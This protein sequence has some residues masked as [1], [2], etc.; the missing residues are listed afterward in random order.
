V[1]SLIRSPP[2]PPYFSFSVP[3]GQYSTLPLYKRLL[4]KTLR[5]DLVPT[6]AIPLAALCIYHGSPP[7]SRLLTPHFSC[8]LPFFIFFSLT[9]TNFSPLSLSHFLVLSTF[10]TLEVSSLVFLF[11]SGNNNT[12]HFLYLRSYYFSDISINGIKK[13]AFISF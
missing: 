1:A 9:N 8:L 2:P 12:L 11:G 10:K 6:E 13:A 4:F 5:S 7:L 3:P